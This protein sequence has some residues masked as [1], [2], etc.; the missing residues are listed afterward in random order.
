MKTNVNP[1]K[2][3]MLLQRDVE[4]RLAQ[5]RD[6]NLIHLRFKRSEAEILA[7][8][9]QGGLSGTFRGIAENIQAPLIEITMR[10]EKFSRQPLPQR[11]FDSVKN[12]ARNPRTKELLDIFEIKDFNSETHS[13]ESLD[14][15]G[16][17]LISKKQVVRQGQRRRNISSDSMFQ[18]I[19][20]SYVE[21]RDEI[22][23][24]AGLE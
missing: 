23:D 19:N 8:M 15:L 14:I 7:E 1:F 9:D 24:A 4:R 12:L 2:L 13:P 20:D 16:D 17:A 10:N 22:R 11:L 6:I 18:A 5:Y 3:Q 21:L